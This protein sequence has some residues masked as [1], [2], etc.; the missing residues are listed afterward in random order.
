MKIVGDR[1]FL[2]VVKN[3]SKT[4]TKHGFIIP[5]NKSVDYGVGK[6]IHVGD[7]ENVSKNIK[8][9]QVVEYK[10]SEDVIEYDENHVVV[11]HSCIFAVRT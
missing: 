11:P 8:V 9:Q 3:I 1:V 2:E 6:V 5:G 7:G 10:F 4:Q